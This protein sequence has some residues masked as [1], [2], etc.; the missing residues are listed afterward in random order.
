M[1]Q[2]ATLAAAAAVSAAAVCALF[3]FPAG[4]VSRAAG[5]LQQAGAAAA[6]E[7]E[8]TAA[9]TAATRQG[10][11]LHL[12]LLLLLLLQGECS[13]SS[14]L[15]ASWVL[16][17]APVVGPPAD[18]RRGPQYSLLAGVAVYAQDKTDPAAAAAAAAA[19]LGVYRQL[20]A[21]NE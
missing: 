12:S 15:R 1:Q 20:S 18:P 11:T 19:V 14:R 21:F 8:A 2:A 6:A 5:T 4:V 17:A 9:T 13:S 7:I 16:P 10:D 3:D